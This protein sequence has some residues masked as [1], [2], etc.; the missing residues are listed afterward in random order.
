MDLYELR[1]Q[2][3]KHKVRVTR[4]LRE[5]LNNDVEKFLSNGGTITQLPAVGSRDVSGERVDFRQALSMT[6][7]SPAEFQA[8]TTMGIYFGIAAPKPV[9]AKGKSYSYLKHE[10]EDFAGKVAKLK[11]GNAA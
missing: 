6:G 1:K 7:L 2:E 3:E 9:G 8:S 10:I 4:H 5:K 11:K